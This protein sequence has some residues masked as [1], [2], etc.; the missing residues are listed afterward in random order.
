MSNAPSKVIRKRRTNAK[1]D[2]R[3]IEVDAQIIRWRR[4]RAKKR[5]ALK[6]AQAEED[7]L[8]TGSVMRNIFE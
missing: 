8:R 7:S 1:R 4:A 3:Y 2:E 5:A 6:A